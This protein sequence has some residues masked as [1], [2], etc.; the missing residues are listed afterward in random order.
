MLDYVRKRNHAEAFT[1]PVLDTALRH[2]YIA[3]VMKYLIRCDNF[4][5]QR[6]SRNYRLEC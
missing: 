2:H 6:C 4:F 1:V 3:R 5:L